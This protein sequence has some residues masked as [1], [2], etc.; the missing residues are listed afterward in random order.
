MSSLVASALFDEPKSFTISELNEKLALPPPP[1][2]RFVRISNVASPLSAQDVRALLEGCL[3][4]PGV[5]NNVKWEYVDNVFHTD[6][7]L[8]LP[9]PRDAHFVVETLR[10]VE[11]QRVPLKVEHVD[12]I[13]SPDLRKTD[14][15]II[16]ARFSDLQ[17][18][19]ASD[20]PLFYRLAQRSAEETALQIAAGEKEL[21]SME[22]QPRPRKRWVG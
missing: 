17:S 12:S 20:P 2:S 7:I 11:F 22:A 19:T 8:Q 16:R 1:P 4:D 3:S 6:I 13:E 14:I 9:T 15:E 5:V 18:T 10:G 21:E